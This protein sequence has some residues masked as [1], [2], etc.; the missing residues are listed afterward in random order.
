MPRKENKIDI[1]EFRGQGCAR[2]AAWMFLNFFILFLVSISLAL[3]KATRIRAGSRRLIREANTRGFRTSEEMMSGAIS[4]TLFSRESRLR[5]HLVR[6]GR[7]RAGRRRPITRGFRAIQMMLLSAA[8]TKTP[9]SKEFRARNHLIGTE[10]RI[11]A[12][13]HFP[14]LK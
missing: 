7:R 2:S 13:R 8:I 11:P 9:F 4:K 14:V 12:M 10:L 6:T 3:M 1:R 5:N